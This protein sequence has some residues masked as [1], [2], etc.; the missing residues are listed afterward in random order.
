MVST[1]AHSELAV[2]LPSTPVVDWPQSGDIDLTIHDLP[3]ATSTLEWWYVNSHVRTLTGR[4]LSL[5]ASFFRTAVGR[6]ESS[7][8]TD[9]AGALTWATIDPVG[10][11]YLRESLVDQ[12]APEIVRQELEQELGIPDPTLRRGLRE[13]VAR[14]STSGPR[15]YPRRTLSGRNHSAS[16]RLRRA[17][18]GEARGWRVCAPASR[19]LPDDWL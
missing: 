16:A 19:R 6:D 8:G 18:P 15:P 7:G 2:A 13:M 1:D 9:D 14:R 11:R 10:E 3:H 5:F 4:E 17:S 12:R